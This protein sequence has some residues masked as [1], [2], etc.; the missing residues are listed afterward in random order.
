MTYPTHVKLVEVGPRDGLQN[1][2]KSLSTEV[3]IAFINRLAAT[4]LR[5]IEATSFVSSSKI[6]QMADASLLLPQVLTIP[7]V[8]FPVLVPNIQGLEAA[9]AAGAKE[10]CLFTAVSETFCQ[11]NID[12][13]IE[14]S[15]ERFK[16]IFAKK[17]KGMKVRGYISCVIAC[18]YEGPQTPQ[19]S[20]DLASALLDLGCY[21]ISLGDTIGVGTP[22]QVAPL[23]D[24]VLKTVPLPQLAVHFHDTYGQALANI[25]LSLTYG[26]N[27][28]D[29]SVSGL[30]GCPYAKGAT[31]N[32][33]TE[34]VVYL[35]QG[36][37]IE[38]GIHLEQ[39]IEVSW[40]ISTALG[41]MPKSKTAIARKPKVV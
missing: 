41:Q 22:G 1:E 5:T 33:A 3:K 26:I 36:L 27:V 2:V 38:T 19:K 35:L 34:D 4:G 21:E 31:G 20:A 16:Q 39:L 28:I 12:C 32:V 10:I 13:S 8:D 30:G 14:Q 24:T 7:H 15:L 25:L 37:G 6:P 29:S 18:P 11:R 9:I 23:L 17:P 40:F